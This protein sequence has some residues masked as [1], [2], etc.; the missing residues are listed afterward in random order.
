MFAEASYV[1]LRDTAVILDRDVVRRVRH[2][3]RPA[4]GFALRRLRAY[5]GFLKL[6]PTTLRT[7]RA[8]HVSPAG[9]RRHR[10]A[11]GRAAMRV[12]VYNA[13]WTTLGG[14]EQLAGGV[15]AALAR[16]HDVELLVGETFDA[17]RRVGTPGLRPHRASPQV[18]VD[19]GTRSFLDASER[20]DFVVN[21][22][23]GN[24]FASR[25]PRNLYYVHFP[26]PNGSIRRWP[27]VTWPVASINPLADW[28]EREHGFWLREFPGNGQLDEGR[29]HHRPRRPTRRPAAVLALALGARRGRRTAHRRRAVHVGDDVVFDGGVPRSRRSASARP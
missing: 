18:Q 26:M 28:I 16:T 1:Y 8:Q 20:Y 4:P 29:R 6:F 25:A 14:G 15:A 3:S 2:R 9:R 7:R 21:T 12:A 11:L 5:A 13:H 27:A 24:T 17:D 19:Q 10:R 23:F 22:S